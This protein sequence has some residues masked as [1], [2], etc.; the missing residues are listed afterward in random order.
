MYSLNMSFTNNI[1]RSLCRD[2][3]SVKMFL[4]YNILIA[5]FCYVCTLFKTVCFAQPYT[6]LV[7]TFDRD[8]KK[9]I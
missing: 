3:V 5:L 9:C 1:F 7:Y 2:Y 4:S 6:K 8:K